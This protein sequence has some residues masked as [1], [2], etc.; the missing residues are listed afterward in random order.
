MLSRVFDLFTQVQPLGDGRAEGLGIGLAL[1]RRLVELH[2]GTVEVRSDGAGLGS[3]FVVRLPPLPNGADAATITILSDTPVAADLKL[4]LAPPKAVH[5]LA[6]CG[7]G[8]GG[9]RAG[10][11]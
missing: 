5:A 8:G 4:T 7:A 2:S 6:R 9:A 11:A 10:T 1:V 3:E